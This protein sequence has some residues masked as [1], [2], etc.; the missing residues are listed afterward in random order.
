MTHKSNTEQELADKVQRMLERV[1]GP[2]RSNV[3][4]SAEV[5]MDSEVTEILTY[6]STVIALI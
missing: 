1:L 4:V 3:I 6:E 5:D 2:G